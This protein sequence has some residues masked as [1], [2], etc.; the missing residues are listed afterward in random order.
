MGSTASTEQT[1]GNHGSRLFIVYAVASLIPVLMLGLVLAGNERK[2]GQ[3]WGLT[4]GRE[5]AAVIEQTALAPA[6]D[7]GDLSE[8]LTKAELQGISQ[9]TDLAIFSGSVTRLRLRSFSGEV[10]FSD[11]GS[12]KESLSISDA[13][14]QTAVNGGTSVQVVADPSGTARQVIR[15]LEPVTPNSSGQATGVLELYLPYA[16]ISAAIKAQLA[17]T[18]V[19]LGVGLGAL[20]AVLALISWSTTRRLRRHAAERHH[21]ALHD[22]LTGLPNRELF[23]CA[24]DAAVR[25]AERGETGALVLVDLDHFKEVNDTLGHHA[26]DAL[27]QVVA[28]RLRASLRTDD[29]VARLGGDEFGILLPG[30]AD[31]PQAVGL[32][33]TIRAALGEEI[34]VDGV[35]LNVEASFGIAMYPAHGTSVE[36]LLQRA[37]SAMYEGKRGT[38]GVVVFTESSAPTTSPGLLIQSELRLALEADE[39]V[40]HYQPKVDLSSGLTFGVEAL[41]RW[42]HPSRGLLG[43]LEFVPAAEQS[44]LVEPLTEWVLRRALADQQHWN[45]RG[46]DW[47]VSV[48]VSARNLSSGSFPRRVKAILEAAG[49][50]PEQLCLEVT[51]TALS[52]NADAAAAAIV[53][54]SGMGIAISIDDFGTGYTSL[55]QIRTLPVAEVKID[56]AFVSDV[57]ESDHD[58]S[59]VQAIIGLSHGLGCTVTAEGVESEAAARW[60][61]LT[62]CD[63]AQGFYFARPRPWPELL[64]HHAGLPPV[65]LPIELSDLSETVSLP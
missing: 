41:V 60:L 62:G 6:L 15:V 19:R 17:R 35:T 5:K 28:Q 43:P 61:R 2:T 24:A 53:E 63:S 56:R 47:Q 10:V 55:W 57:T 16:Q 30:L 46:V 64:E 42:Q 14:F 20:Y 39:L 36:Q 12:R 52:A 26:G 45:R 51:E 8:G 32:L 38:E 9:A 58:R 48:N 7:S 22:S 18:Y 37:D 34:V 40:L 31:A 50:R 1:A 11:D 29:T 4:Q 13:A 23:R 25:R 44:G 3:D 54:L 33:N 27:L 65:P 21:Q 49:A 59:I